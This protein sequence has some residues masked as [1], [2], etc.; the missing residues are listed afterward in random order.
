MRIR[1]VKYVG[2]GIVPVRSVPGNSEVPNPH[3]INKIAALDFDKQ[4]AVGPMQRMCPKSHNH[5]CSFGFSLSTLLYV[6]IRSTAWC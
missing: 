3:Q 1:S 4:Q 5:L 2:P 6:E